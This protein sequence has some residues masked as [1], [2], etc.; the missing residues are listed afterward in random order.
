LAASDE[1]A[2]AVDTLS[3]CLPPALSEL[4]ADDREAI[5]LCDLQGMRQAQFFQ[6]Q[7]VNLSTA[8]SRLQRALL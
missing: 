4:S 1:V 7:G 2:D 3:V 8:K 5:A 6:R